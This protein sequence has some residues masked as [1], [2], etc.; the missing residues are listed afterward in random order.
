MPTKHKRKRGDDDSHFNLPPTTKAKSLPVIEPT[1]DFITS[2]KKQKLDTNGKSKRVK[3]TTDDT[4][5]TFA[6]LMAWHQGGKKIGGGLDNGNTQPK[7]L[8]KKPIDLNRTG[9]S[10][11][12]NG[13]EAPTTS[14][15]QSMN[16]RQAIRRINS[17][18]SVRSVN[19]EKLRRTR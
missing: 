10:A 8:K 12:T 9:E 14:S 6:R 18:L 11:S 4:P 13:T 7:K 5:K 3:H 17:P 2:W 19:S 15:A 1:K 16:C